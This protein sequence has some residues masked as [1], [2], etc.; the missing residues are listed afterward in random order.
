MK[1]IFKLFL[2][3][4]LC[5]ALNIS[6]SFAVTEDIIF[7][8]KIIDT[9]G[10]L[11]KQL[12]RPGTKSKYN[13]FFC[14]E[15]G[16]FELY[17]RVLP[18]L[19]KYSKVNFIEWLNSNFPGFYH[20]NKICLQSIDYNEK[21]NNSVNNFIYK[22]GSKNCTLVYFS[23]SPICTI[24]GVSMMLIKCFNEECHIITEK[25]PLDEKK[26]II[27]ECNNTLNRKYSLI[28]SLYS[29]L[30]NTSDGIHDILN[31]NKEL[32]I[33]PNIMKVANLID[34]IRT[35]VGK[36]I[37]H[38]D[39]FYRNKTFYDLKKVKDSDSEDS[40]DLSENEAYYIEDD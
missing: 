40:V 28:E 6:T 38:M 23:M 32:E 13:C 1:G 31:I 15:K 30:K 5:F 29:L 9:N 7:I 16:G 26:L 12:T 11:S 24:V 35:F 33:Y 19:N 36:T 34:E 27:S 10:S 37:N 25:R 2:V 14:S 39:D 20:N 8:R 3:S 21:L 4:F 17:F 18:S 22:Y